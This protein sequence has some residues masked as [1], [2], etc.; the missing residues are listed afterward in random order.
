MSGTG[1][2]ALVV[3]GASAGGVAA[4]RGLISRLGPVVDRGDPEAVR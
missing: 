4:L 2:S 3:V 1:P